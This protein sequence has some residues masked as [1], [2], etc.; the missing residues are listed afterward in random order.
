M[1]QSTFPIHDDL[2]E[3]G[4]VRKRQMGAFDFTD[5]PLSPMFLPIGPT[6]CRRTRGM[7]YLAGL[8]ERL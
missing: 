1:G 7:V 4:R 2:P 5:R 3:A 8:L 6:T